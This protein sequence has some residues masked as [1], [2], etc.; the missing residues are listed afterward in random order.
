MTSWFK[1]DIIAK[2][3]GRGNDSSARFKVGQEVKIISAPPG[4]KEWI[5]TAVK[6]RA[7]NL[8]DFGDGEQAFEYLLTKYPL[9]LWEEELEA[10]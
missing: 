9:V 7:M 2:H 5:G 10:A 8:T 4:F 6:V 1:K 3:W